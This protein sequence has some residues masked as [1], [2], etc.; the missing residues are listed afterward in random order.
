MAASVNGSHRFGTAVA[1]STR[2]IRVERDQAIPELE[3]VA[4]RVWRREQTLRMEPSERREDWM[5]AWIALLFLIQSRGMT[6]VRMAYAVALAGLRMP[7]CVAGL[8]RSVI[9]VSPS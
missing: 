1:P 2:T 9:R 6:T 7:S 5:D 8:P 3:Y 4:T